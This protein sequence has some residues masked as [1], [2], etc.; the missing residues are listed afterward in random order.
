MMTRATDTPDESRRWR[1]LRRFDQVMERIVP[2]IAIL[3]GVLALVATFFIW[4]NLEDKADRAEVKADQARV[5]LRSA[6]RGRKIAREA[7]CGAA[8]G[9][10]RAGRA[11]LTGNLVPGMR[12]DTAE[13]RRMARQSARAYNA[14]ISEAVIGTAGVEG[15]DLLRANGTI[16]CAALTRV[17]TTPRP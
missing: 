4:S 8:T 12:P 9:I 16:D 1:W 17:A 13:A 3:I 11:A 6:E 14:I 5:E 10:Q 7:L 15:M 2:T